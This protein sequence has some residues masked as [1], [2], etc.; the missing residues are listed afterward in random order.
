[1]KLRFIVL[2]LLLSVFMLFGNCSQASWATG[3]KEEVLTNINKLY[4]G[5]LISIVTRDNAINKVNS[6]NTN[7]VISNYYILYGKGNNNNYGYK[8]A[9]TN[10]LYLTFIENSPTVVNLNN[11][12]S[13][14]LY[15]NWNISPFT[16]QVY[17]RVNDNGASEYSY[18]AF[19]NL[20]NPFYCY[21][22][23]N[24][25][26]RILTL[27]AGEEYGGNYI[28]PPPYTGPVFTPSNNTINVYNNNQ[29][30]EVANRLPFGYVFPNTSTLGY[31]S[32]YSENF[33][34]LDVNMSVVNEIDANNFYS[35]NLASLNYNLYTGTRSNGLQ[36]DLSN[37]KLSVTSTLLIPNQL[38]FLTIYYKD[39]RD[40]DWLYVGDKDYSFYS[41]F[42]TTSPTSGDA[43]S[44][45]LVKTLSPEIINTMREI[46]NNNPN[47][48]YIIN[49]SIGLSSGDINH[50]GFPSGELVSGDFFG[51]NYQDYDDFGFGDFVY[52]FFY[53]LY[54]VLT[55]YNNVTIDFGILGS[56]NSSQFVIS[57]PFLA[58]FVSLFSNAFLIIVL[59]WFYYYF[60][61]HI[62]ILD[63]EKIFKYDIDNLFDL[64]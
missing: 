23:V 12:T 8:L 45:D 7:F 3:V 61:K 16:N 38:Y 31:L 57:E 5:G 54:Y 53:G 47:Y 59:I 30:V 24:I 1:M 13:N 44:P 15:N 56:F 26:T 33:Y 9:T 19:N 4:N 11:N 39:T 46:G 14:A 6:V 48:P 58:N 18:Q 27:N 43:I 37:G 49:N 34:A 35:D 42:Y 60:Y 28:T 2:F 36:F 52:R 10:F 20:V 55:D 41:Y 21:T 63:L 25:N 51:I 29:L 22:T 64:F 17:Y 32:D 62:S 40:D 50:N